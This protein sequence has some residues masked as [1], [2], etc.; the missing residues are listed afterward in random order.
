MTARRSL[1]LLLALAV[2]AGVLAGCGGGT[3][4][5]APV[6]ASEKKLEGMYEAC[7]NIQLVD[8]ESKTTISVAS[9]PSMATIEKQAVLKRSNGMT[10]TDTWKGTPLVAVLD[11]KGVARPFK[12]LKVTAW[13][14][15]VGRVGY[16]IAVAPDT[17][18][19]YRVNGKPIPK[20]DGPVR[21]VVPSQ[22][23]FYWIRMITKI[24]VL[25]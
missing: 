25:R 14:G 8:G 7:R 18:L 20:E 22:D 13:D 5:K 15:Y 16:E 24:E 17:M 23:G 3:S 9:L 6:L 12:E 19:A 21:L 4:S 10:R 2:V 1:A 11:L